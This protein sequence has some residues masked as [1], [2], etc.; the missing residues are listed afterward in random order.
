MKKLKEETRRVGYLPAPGGYP[1]PPPL[2]CRQSAQAI[3]TP[4]FKG[5]WKLKVKDKGENYA[6]ARVGALLA[7]KGEEQ[8]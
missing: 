8:G 6:R 7:G 1:P 5:D 2:P 3:S 4:L